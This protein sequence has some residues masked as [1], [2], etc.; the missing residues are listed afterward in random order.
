MPTPRFTLAAAILAMSLL[1]LAILDRAPE[2]LVTGAAR[3]LDGDSV[4]VNGR[5]MRLK[6]MDA[7]EAHQT[8][9]IAGQQTPCGRQATIAL[10]RW[11]ARGPLTCTGRE[12]D[13]YNRLL[14][15]CRVNGQD[16]G[17]DMVRNGFAV[18]Y[19]SYPDEEKAAAAEFRGIWAG[20]FERPEAYRRRMRESG[21]ASRHPPDTPSMRP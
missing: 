6:G 2:E 17:A 10:R 18:D 21:Q 3:A 8:C 12:I 19:G 15:V 14:V 20:T 4:V 1:V 7:P 16:I 9:E 5:E 11:L 13:R